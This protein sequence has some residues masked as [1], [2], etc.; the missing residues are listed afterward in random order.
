MPLQITIRFNLDDNVTNLP[1]N[2]EF[3]AKLKCNG[4]TQNGK[5]TIPLTLTTRNISK[6][7]GN[8]PD[9]YEYFI[10][11]VWIQI[12]DDNDDDDTKRQSNRF[13]F[14]FTKEQ[15]EADSNIYL[16]DIDYEDDQDESDIIR[17]LA[18]GRNS[19]IIIGS[20]S[21]QPGS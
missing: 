19:T 8:V 16:A 14:Y 12:N 9:G 3:K 7:M 1:D 6:L 21:P 11:V 15:Y 20:G 10:I 13:R 17:L 5:K 18:S 4:A 2:F